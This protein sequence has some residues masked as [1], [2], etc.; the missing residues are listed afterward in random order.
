MY[1]LLV[2]S[3]EFRICLFSFPWVAIIE[4]TAIWVCDKAIILTEGQRYEICSPFEVKSHAAAQKTKEKSFG[5]PSSRTVHR[6]A[7]SEKKC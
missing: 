4:F 6:D 5:N 1:H 7:R 2:L 3:V